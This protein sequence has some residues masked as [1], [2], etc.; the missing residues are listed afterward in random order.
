MK[1]LLLVFPY[2][3]KDET[4]FNR[5][6]DKF[7]N[8]GYGIVN[9]NGIDSEF[10]IGQLPLYIEHAKEQVKNKVERITILSN[11]KEIIFSWYRCYNSLV[12]EFVYC[13]DEDKDF[14]NGKEM[15][16]D[17]YYRLSNFIGI[18]NEYIQGNIYINIDFENYSSLIKFLLINNNFKYFDELTNFDFNKELKKEKVKK[19]YH[20]NNQNIVFETDKEIKKQDMVALTKRK[21]HE[22]FKLNNKL[23]RKLFNED[24]LYFVP[25]LVIELY[26]QSN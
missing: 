24:N 13:I 9:F 23:K 21:K 1:K 3:V 22:N 26:K 2:Q 6:I 17:F 11:V 20:Y 5:I 18:D 12:N 19:R 16:T 4:E 7:D 15:Y 8:E 25:F 14:L 10:D